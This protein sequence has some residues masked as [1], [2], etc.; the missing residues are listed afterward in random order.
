MIKRLTFGQY[1]CKDSFLHSLDARIKIIYVVVLGILSFGIKSK[2]EIVVFSLFMACIVLLSK[3]SFKELIKNLRPF[4]FVFI[5]LL[6]MYLIF[7]RDQIILGLRYIWRF[8]LLIIISMLLTYTTTIQELIAAIE[9]LSKPLKV[10][11]IKPRNMAVM[12]SVAVRF[13]PLMFIRFERTREA[14]ASRLADFRKIRHIKL[15]VLN[16]LEKMLR[17]ASNLSDAMHSRLYNEDIES[18]KFMKL[19]SCDYWSVAIIAILILIIY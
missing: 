17:S 14:M 1:R 16:L 11:K 8:L 19:K 10:F 7:S 12:I 15:L 9:K 4:Y 3:M 6:L 18:R 2:F 5:F 13:I